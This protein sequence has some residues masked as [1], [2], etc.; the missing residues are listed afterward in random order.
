[1]SDDRYNFFDV[2]HTYKV[3]KY[4]RI[5]SIHDNIWRS[6]RRWRVPDIYDINQESEYVSNYSYEIIT[7][8]NCWQPT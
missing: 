4:H 7:D 1:M 3:D 5:N 6:L 2:V 8:I